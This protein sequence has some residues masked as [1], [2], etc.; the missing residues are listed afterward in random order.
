MCNLMNDKVQ[1]IFKYL[2]FFFK[3]D[4]YPNRPIE[5][6]AEMNSSLRHQKYAV[7]LV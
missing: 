1:R 4:T 5:A 7:Q 3:P 6:K 2:F